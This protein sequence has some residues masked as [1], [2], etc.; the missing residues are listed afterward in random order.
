MTYMLLWVCLNLS[1]DPTIDPCGAYNTTAD[2]VQCYQRL[3]V[4]LDT[5][6]EEV[7]NRISDRL[8]QTRGEKAAAAFA[9]S[10]EAWVKARETWI[11]LQL[12][13]SEGGSIAAL[14]K[15]VSHHTWAS[16]RLEQLQGLDEQLHL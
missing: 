4:T 5:E 9:T 15:V 16:L 8:K 7:A 6:L 13:L 10:Q 14:H 3:N 2:I 12:E 1:H 11:A